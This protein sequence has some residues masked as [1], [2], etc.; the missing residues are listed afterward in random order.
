MKNQEIKNMVN[1][2][3]TA[4][5]MGKDEARNEIKNVIDSIDKNTKSLTLTKGISVIIKYKGENYYDVVD[6][7]QFSKTDERILTIRAFLENHKSPYRDVFK[8][9]AKHNNDEIF[10]GESDGIIPPTAEIIGID[11]KK[12]AW[13]IAIWLESIEEEIQTIENEL[14]KPD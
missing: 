5:Y 10:I 13:K 3:V 8:A 9:I 2:I 6:I 4:L 14:D 11:Y 1:T 12:E 7:S